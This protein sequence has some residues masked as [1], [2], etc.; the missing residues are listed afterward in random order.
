MMKRRLVSGSLF[1]FIIF[2]VIY[3]SYPFVLNRLA[4][5]LVTRAKLSPADVILVLAGDTDGERV[6]AGVNLYKK[7]YAKYLLMSGGELAWRLTSAEWMK[8]QAM[9]E[10]VAGRAIL[11]QDKSRSTI[12]DATF[13]LPIVKARGFK[14]VIIVT[15]PYHTSRAARVFKKIFGPAGVN[16]MVYPAEEKDFNPNRWWSRHEDAGL[17]VWEYVSSV[18]YFLKGY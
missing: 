4:E 14:S 17:V 8:K 11:L 18:L 2:L 10:G 1:L 3:F 16:V 7:G 5:R 13:P 12:D 15:S 9:A 6:T